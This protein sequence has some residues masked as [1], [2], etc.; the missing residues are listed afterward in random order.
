MSQHSL[1][2]LK[3]YTIS[4]KNP[5]RY[6][7]VR[8]KVISTD[9]EKARFV[10]AEQARGWRE[11]GKYAHEFLSPKK[12]TVEVQTIQDGAVLSIERY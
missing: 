10:A 8:V 2:G 9:E 6:Q 5:K 11:I 12:S 3:V 4:R 7:I 1:E